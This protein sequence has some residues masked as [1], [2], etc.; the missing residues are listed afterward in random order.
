M[1]I[2]MSNKIDLLT[3]DK[4]LS[5]NSLI[6]EAQL[7]SQSIDN[8]VHYCVSAKLCKGVED[9]FLDLTRRLLDAHQKQQQTN[10]SNVTAG[11][12]ARTL[13]ITDDAD[14]SIPAENLNKCNC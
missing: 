4:Q 7:Y 6:S 1:A 10:K 3:S 12:S 9:L 13:R 8:A 14:T 11:S 5:S 2:R